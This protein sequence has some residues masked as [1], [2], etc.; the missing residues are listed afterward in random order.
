MVYAV[1]RGLGLGGLPQRVAAGQ[2]G[3][4]GSQRRELGIDLGGRVGP[5][6]EQVVDAGAELDPGGWGQGWER[7]GLERDPRCWRRLASFS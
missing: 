1:D 5:V 3:S 6:V 2:G 7:L 4:G